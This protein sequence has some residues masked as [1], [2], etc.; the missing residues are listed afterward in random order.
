MKQL[1][2]KIGLTLLYLTPVG[3]ILRLISL[4]T[5][6]STPGVFVEMS[7]HKPI[8]VVVKNNPTIGDRFHWLVNGVFLITQAFVIIKNELGASWGGTYAYVALI[9]GITNAVAAFFPS[10]NWNKKTGNIFLLLI[11]ASSLL[12]VASFTDL[13]NYFHN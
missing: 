3:Y 11:I 10:L 12:F 13:I 1:L 2:E 5:G 4:Q 8:I 6:N 9:F 7:K